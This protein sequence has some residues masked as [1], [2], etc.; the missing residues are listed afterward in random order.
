MP[1]GGK[2]ADFKKRK[3]KLGKKKLAPTS[4]TATQFKTRSVVL[5]E[6]AQFADGRDTQPTTSRGSHTLPE[7]LAQLRHYSPD[8]RRDALLGL[9]DLLHDH[10][11]LLHTHAAEVLS[12]AAPLVSDTAARVRRALLT[13][14]GAVL[15]R[16][17]QSAALAP[18]EPLLRLNLQAALSREEPAVRADAVDAVALL[19][20][21][22]PAA[23]LIESRIIYNEDFLVKENTI[24]I[25]VDAIKT[26]FNNVDFDGTP[27][28]VRG[29]VGRVG[30]GGGTSRGGGGGAGSVD[31]GRKLP[32]ARLAAVVRPI[33]A[34]PA[35]EPFFCARGRHGGA[36]IFGPFLA[37]PRAQRQAALHL[38]LG[39]RP[40]SRGLLCALARCALADA[41][42]PRSGDVAVELVRAVEAGGWSGAVD[43]QAQASFYAT[44]LAEA[45]GAGAQPPG[46]E[47]VRNAALG[48]L[49]RAEVDQGAAFVLPAAR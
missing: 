38:V 8:V 45:G 12:G 1:K 40:I 17:E 20:A 23:L 27:S 9:N 25:V 13:L 28:E 16:L 19:L 11:S 24:S 4:T 6:Q 32:P 49:R 42:P 29:V 22:R 39:L 41:R 10:P 33:E 30:G 34:L 47:A 43:A 5:L 35:L 3:Q 2:T 18:H 7:L 36:P 37:L 14:L 44:L 26:L 15:P 48:A 31:E 21:G 46:A